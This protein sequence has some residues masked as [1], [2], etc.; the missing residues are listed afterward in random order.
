MARAPRLPELLDATA[1]SPPNRAGDSETIY[2]P[3]LLENVPKTNLPLEQVYHTEEEWLIRRHGTSLETSS[4]LVWRVAGWRSD[5]LQQG[6]T[7]YKAGP[8]R[9]S[10][11]GEHDQVAERFSTLHRPYRVVDSL[12]GITSG[13][14]LIELDPALPI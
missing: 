6:A 7:R 3:S 10:V 14:Q 2:A 9:S 1:V 4:P 8:F 11:S 13:N 12:K 5:T